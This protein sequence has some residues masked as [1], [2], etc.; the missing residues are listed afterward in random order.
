MCSSSGVMLAPVEIKRYGIRLDV[1]FE[2]VLE[3]FER[4]RSGVVTVKSFPLNL[5]KIRDVIR[6]R[7]N[8]GKQ[9]SNPRQASSTASRTPQNLPKKP[10]HA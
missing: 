5:L 4:N 7:R 3:L 10:N 2:D 8:T 9:R 1:R 6:T